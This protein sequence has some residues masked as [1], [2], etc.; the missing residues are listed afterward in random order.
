M[1][2]R[3]GAP[4]VLDDAFWDEFLKEPPPDKSPYQ[5]SPS[6]EALPTPPG[7]KAP[8]LGETGI[9]GMIVPQLGPRAPK[10]KRARTE[11]MNAPRQTGAQAKKR[12]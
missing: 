4:V 3:R 10:K 1:T 9:P 12:R 7:F 2:T 5:I 8:D 6:S 11:R